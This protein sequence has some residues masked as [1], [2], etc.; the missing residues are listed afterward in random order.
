MNDELKDELL[1]SSSFIVP[2]SSFLFITGVSS[3][4]CQFAQGDGEVARGAFDAVGAGF[5]FARVV[6][7]AR[8]DAGEGV[9]DL[10]VE[11]FGCR[12]GLLLSIG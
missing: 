3:S 10:R 4:S 6:R 11:P 2:T 7:V 12:F 1:F 8:G 5:E 9:F